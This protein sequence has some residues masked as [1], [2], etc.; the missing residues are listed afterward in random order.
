MSTVVVVDADAHDAVRLASHLQAEGYEVEA[1]TSGS[2]G[3]RLVR[4]RKPDMLILDLGVRDIAGTEVCRT[5]RA[6]ASLRDVSLLLTSER[7]DEI[8]RVVGFEVG[9]DDFVGKPWSLREL[10]LRVRAILR[11]RRLPPRRVPS[12]RGRTLTIDVEGRRV[13][14]DGAEVVLSALEFELLR[15]LSD[16]C[17]CVHS[18]ASLLSSVWRDADGVNARTVDACIKRLRQKLGRAG[19]SIQTVRGIGYRLVDWD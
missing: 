13:R 11:R 14:V 2:T 17:Q 15:T 12:P 3:L 1:S 19:G 4:E 8:D 16:R 10:G 18:R 7:A 5:V 6:D 9:A